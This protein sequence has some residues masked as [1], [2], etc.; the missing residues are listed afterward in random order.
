MITNEKIFGFES[1][2]Q[3]ERF[4]LIKQHLQQLSSFEQ[5]LIKTIG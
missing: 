3:N 1:R 4:G 2:G 5:V